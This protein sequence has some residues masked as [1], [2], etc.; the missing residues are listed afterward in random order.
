MQK[1]Y[2]LCRQIVKSSYTIMKKSTL[3]LL[4]ALLIGHMTYAENPKHEFRATWLTTGFGIDW[5][6]TKNLELQKE[7]LCDIL[8]VMAKGNMNAVCLQVRSFA[9]A[10]YQSSYEPW[11]S[12]LTGTRG[13]DPGYDPLAFAIEEA[14]KR[15]IKVIPYFGFEISTLSPY[16]QAMGEEVMV[17][18]VSVNTLKEISMPVDFKLNNGKVLSVSYENKK[19]YPQLS[20]TTIE[21]LPN[22]VKVNLKPMYEGNDNVKSVQPATFESPYIYMELK[23]K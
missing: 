14:H 3:F 22:M 8:D 7:S 1:I 18:D 16:W 11:S 12:I 2:Y 17:K 15:G 20:L 23:N 10:I 6:K 13:E 9:D 21:E 5:P 19:N 4:L